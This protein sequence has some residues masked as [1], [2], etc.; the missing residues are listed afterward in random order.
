MSTSIR[1]TVTD[2]WLAGVTAAAAAVL[3]LMPLSAHPASAREARPATTA[4]A[5]W[6]AEPLSSLGG[7]TLAQY[8]TDHQALV[9]GPVRC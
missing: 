3:V 2:R 7:R 5:P 8:V 6:Y 9:L 4:P 1:S